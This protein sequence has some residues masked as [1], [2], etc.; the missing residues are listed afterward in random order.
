VDIKIHLCTNYVVCC[1]F[2]LNC[3]YGDFLISHESLIIVRLTHVICWPHAANL[4]FEC[5]KRIFSY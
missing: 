4:R 1:G 3:E 5:C 2:F